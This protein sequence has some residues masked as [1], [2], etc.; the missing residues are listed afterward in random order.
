MRIL[1]VFPLGL[2]HFTCIL[3]LGAFTFWIEYMPSTQKRPLYRTAV[4]LRK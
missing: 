3:H 4:G 2:R 1:S